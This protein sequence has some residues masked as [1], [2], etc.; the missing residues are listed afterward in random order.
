MLRYGVAGAIGRMK[1]GSTFPIET[2]LINVSGCLVIGLLAGLGEARGAFSAPARS[3]LFVGLLGGFTTFSAF[4]HE[5]LQLL[6]GGQW[7]AAMMSAGLQVIL[8]V[9]AVALGHTLALASR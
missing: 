3:F 6:R 5:T 4:G 9:S 7:P 8:G 2:L 1:G